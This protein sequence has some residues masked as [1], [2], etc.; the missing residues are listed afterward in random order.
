[1]GK[2]D[3]AYNENFPKYTLTEK[4]KRDTLKRFLESLVV[5]EVIGAMHLA[6]SKIPDPDRAISYFCGICWNKIRGTTKNE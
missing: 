2:I 3:N 6:C 5:E 1:M 4:F